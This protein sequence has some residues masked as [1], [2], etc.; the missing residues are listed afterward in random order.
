MLTIERY[1]TQVTEYFNQLK[2][3]SSSS[4]TRPNTNPQQQSTPISDTNPISPLSTTSQTS[5]SD[6]STSSGNE[7]HRYIYD[8]SKLMLNSYYSTYYWNK[9]ENLVREKTLKG[10]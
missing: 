6:M 10:K 5:S 3:P 2:N 8:F 7:Q 1:A 9:A 4:S